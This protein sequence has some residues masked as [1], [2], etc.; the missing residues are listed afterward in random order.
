MTDWLLQQKQWFSAVWSH[1]MLEFQLQQIILEVHWKPVTSSSFIWKWDK[2]TNSIAV[3]GL[4]V[5]ELL[6]GAHWHYLL[7]E[8]I[9]LPRSTALAPI[10]GGKFY[11]MEHTVT[12]VGRHT[13][14]QHCMLEPDTAIQAQRR[15]NLNMPLSHQS[16]PL[17]E[18]KIWKW[19]T[20]YVIWQDTDLYQTPIHQETKPSWEGT[21]R[22]WYFCLYD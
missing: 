21:K 10:H 18:A 22:H 17:L 4:R 11:F 5:W 14:T 12:V 7:N 15:I 3:Q 19:G 8:L 9:G 13:N 1:I 6:W 20:S 16:R 2:K